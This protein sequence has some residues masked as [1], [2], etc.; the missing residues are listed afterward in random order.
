MATAGALD[1]GFA[2]RLLLRG[3]VYCAVLIIPQ[4]NARLN[5]TSSFSVIT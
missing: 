4:L 2:L 3:F 1:A 5:V